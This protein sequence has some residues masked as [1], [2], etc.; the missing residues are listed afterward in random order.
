MVMPQK[1]MDSKDKRVME[2]HRLRYMEDCSNKEIAKRIGVSLPTVERYFSDSDNDKFKRFYSDQQ[3]FKL[4]QS[5]EQ[6][7]KDGN[8]EAKELLSRAMQH[9][10]AKPSTLV[11]AS[12]EAQK[13]RQRKIDML[14]EL[15]IIEKKPDKEIHRDNGNGES[16]EDRLAEAYQ[17]KMQE[18]KDGEG[19]REEVLE[20]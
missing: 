17:Q 11:R 20:A 4:E 2:A 9:P 18:Q 7:V 1:A 3:L 16:V 10:E 12:K 8:N 15:G 13:I 6:D 14:Q 19:D 5:L